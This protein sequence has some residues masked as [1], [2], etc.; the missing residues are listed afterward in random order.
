V[1]HASMIT[2]SDA[3]TAT[4]DLARAKDSGEPVVIVRGLAAHVSDDDGPGA[5]ALIRPLAED[6]FL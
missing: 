4:A 3:A 6:L 2:L 1:R 5:A